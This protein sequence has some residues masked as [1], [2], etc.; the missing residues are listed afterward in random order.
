MGMFG[1][2]GKLG[3]RAIAKK[4]GLKGAAVREFG[5]IGQAVGDTVPVP[6]YK[7]GGKVKKTGFAKIH[8]GEYILP[9]EI[10]PTKSQVKKVAKLKAQK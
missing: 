8:K 10:K 6:A 1:K 3:G 2:L 4:I 9:K 7:R 5:N